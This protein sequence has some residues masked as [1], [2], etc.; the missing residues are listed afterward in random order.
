MGEDIRLLIKEILAEELASLRA[1]FHGDATVERVSVATSAELS[2]FALSL[3]DRANEPGFAS[4]LRNGRLRFEPVLDF[5]TVA[6][7]EQA[8]AVA[9]HTPVVKQPKTLVTTVPAKVP[10]LTKC[11]ITERDLAV[12]ADGETRLRIKKTARLTPLAND[13]LRRRGIKIERTIE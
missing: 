3:L 1:A 11:L 12:V 2:R 6:R 5:G 8:P 10:E 9:M 4:A 13:E 7:L